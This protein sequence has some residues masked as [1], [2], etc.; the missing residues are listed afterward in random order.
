MAEPRR[1]PAWLWMAGM[2]FGLYFS[3]GIAYFE[4]FH[5]P[6]QAAWWPYLP[7][8]AILV[9]VSCALALA[10]Y[11]RSSGPRRQQLQA[12]AGLPLAGLALTGALLWL[13]G[14]ALD[15]QGHSWHLLGQIYTVLL[16]V[17]LLPVLAALILLSDRIR[18]AVA[19]AQ[20]NAQPVPQASADAPQP[21]APDSPAMLHL[22]AGD[23]ALHIPV[24]DIILLEAADNYI[25]FHYLKDQQ[26]RT[27]VL[28]MQMKV[29]EASLAGHPGFYRCHRSYLVNGHMVEA[30]LGSAQ[31]HRLQVRHI[32]EP[33]P[34]SRSFDIGPLRRAIS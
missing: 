19:S 28:R 12:Y 18:P 15:A 8:A 11:R 10:L 26:R 16:L 22:E 1:T 27:K 6:A 21:S 17:G 29:A 4:A 14:G 20:I 30:V 32:D 7:V 5:F 25:K 9:A 13:V 24:A 34:V 3:L 2:G 33:V 23:A 31:N